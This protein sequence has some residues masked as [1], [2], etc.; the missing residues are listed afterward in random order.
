MSQSTP[1]KIPA[2]LPHASGHQFV[3]YGDACSGVS[4]A[5][6]EETF[7]AT[8]SIVQRLEPAPEFLI[9]AGDEIRGLTTSEEDL[10]SQW[11]FWFEEE[12]AWL[13]REKTPIYHCTSNHTTYNR[14]SERVFADV[15][16]RMPRNG[17]VDQLGLSYFVRNGDLLMVFIHTS[18]SGQGGEGHIETRWLKSV[19]QANADA[20]HKFVVGHHPVFPVN[21]YAG[22]YDI[23]IGREYASEF[24]QLLVDHDV[25]AY[26]CS[27]VLAFD[28]QVHDGVLQWL[29]GGAG[30]AHRMPEGIE[31][32]HCVQAKIDNTGLQYQ[33]LDQSGRVKE[34]LS[35]PFSLDAMSPWI[36]ASSTQLASKDLGLGSEMKPIVAIHVCAVLAEDSAA[37]QTLVAAYKDDESLPTLWVGLTGQCQ[38]LTVTLA[39]TP[40][41]SPQYWFGPSLANLDERHKKVCELDLYVVLHRHMGPGGM[42]FRFGETGAWHSMESG[43]PVGIGK[44][45]LPDLWR[46]GAD[47]SGERS[48][49]GRDLRVRCCT[50][51][52][53]L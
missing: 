45:K 31:Y 23:V 44:L 27:H 4:G 46:I 40:G 5:L 53:S 12:M 7:A 36:T 11:A 50:V 26:L 10:R 32:L 1:D 48:F 43:M 3:F 25:F 42:L 49:A 29:S 8:N 22:E 38:R 39:P 19:L 16:R 21:G 20:R 33:V 35:W 30:T 47:L 24:W 6:H 17:P 41:R 52:G 51:D 9:F 34:R 28:V 14:M 2:L 18:W 15:M 13:D 37:A